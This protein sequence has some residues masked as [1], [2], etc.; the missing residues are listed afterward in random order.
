MSLLQ[1]LNI[2]KWCHHF[3][4]FKMLSRRHETTLQTFL[5]TVWRMSYQTVKKRFIIRKCVNECLATWMIIKMLISIFFRTNDT[6]W[7]NSF[8]R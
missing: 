3:W 6:R 5:L 4:T 7:Q 8:W 2:W 1:D